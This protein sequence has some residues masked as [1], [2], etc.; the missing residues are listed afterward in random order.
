MVSRGI[1]QRVPLHLPRYTDD[2]PVSTHSSEPPPTGHHA[3]TCCNVTCMDQNRLPPSQRSSQSPPPPKR[4][5]SKKWKFNGVNSLTGEEVWECPKSR[6]QHL[7]FSSPENMK[8]HCLQCNRYDPKP[9]LDE[10][11]QPIDQTVTSPTRT[12]VEESRGRYT[13]LCAYD[14]KE[15][16]ATR[17]D[18]QYCSDAHR[19]AAYRQGI[20][21]PLPGE[22]GMICQLDGCTATFKAIR[23]N[24][25]FCCDS[26]R[27]A[28]YKMAHNLKPKSS[29]I[30]CANPNCPWPGRTFIPQYPEHRYCCRSCGI[31]MRNQ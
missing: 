4:M 22:S 16:N 25:R 8:L 20:R 18:A 23:A 26:H 10:H 19:Q 29:P 6:G 1:Y 11:G 9:D 12:S 27:V 28:A 15:F 2:H 30:S 17:R 7:V 13:L 5:N 3:I 31:E 21:T 24:Q 14:G